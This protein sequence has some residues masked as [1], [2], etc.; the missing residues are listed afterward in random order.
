[1][2]LLVEFVLG[3]KD[4]KETS[5][6]EQKIQK[7]LLNLVSNTSAT[8]EEKTCYEEKYFFK[9]FNELAYRAFN[10]NSLQII[11]KQSNQLSTFYR[12]VKESKSSGRREL[13]F[14]R[15]IRKS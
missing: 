1:M 3:C 7:G 10:G 11:L 5:V 4:G 2:D 14:A 15:K 9:A 12:T 6:N 13:Y 8:L